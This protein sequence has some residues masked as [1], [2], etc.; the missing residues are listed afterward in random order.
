VALPSADTPPTLWAILHLRWKFYLN[1]RI[2]S[3]YRY[4][5]GV[6]MVKCYHGSIC[7]SCSQYH[8]SSHK[9]SYGSG[10]TFL[11]ANAMQIGRRMWRRIYWFLC[12]HSGW[13]TY[14]MQTTVSRT[15]CGESF[16]CFIIEECSLRLCQV[17]SC[18]SFHCSLCC[19]I[20]SSKW[21]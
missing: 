6:I 11:F 19:V 18:S 13:M 2:V 17:N 16:F 21:L 7:F 9:F 4:K 20:T 12:D 3:N 14:S 1:E 15:F 10:D 5:S 8:S